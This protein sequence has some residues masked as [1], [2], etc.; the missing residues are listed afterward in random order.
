MI[1]L[2]T[3]I[4]SGLF[5]L[6]AD[7][8]TS[9]AMFSLGEELI[10]EEFAREINSGRLA[11]EDAWRNYWTFEDDGSLWDLPNNVQWRALLRDWRRIIYA[12]GPKLSEEMLSKTVTV[13]SSNYHNARKIIKIN[14]SD[15]IGLNL[16]RWS[17]VFNPYKEDH[18]LALYLASNSSSLSIKIGEELINLFR[19]LSELQLTPA[20]DNVFKD[21]CIINYYHPELNSV[22]NAYSDNDK[23]RLKALGKKEFIDKFYVGYGIKVNSDLGPA[24]SVAY[25][26]YNDQRDKLLETLRLIKSVNNCLPDSGDDGLEVSY[27]WESLNPGGYLAPEKKNKTHKTSSQV[28]F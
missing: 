20:G 1:H 10:A 24:R 23:A 26:F 22:I 28:P 16:P 11:V 18:R 21:L 4:Q 5:A 2:D 7:S 8:Q 13:L 15:Y 14:Y 9:P 3:I 25:G 12:I 17:W 6:D 19:P 27:A